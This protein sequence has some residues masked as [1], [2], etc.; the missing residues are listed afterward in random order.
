MMVVRGRIDCATV[1]NKSLQVHV[2]LLRLSSRHGAT[3]RVIASSFMLGIVDLDSIFRP[4]Q[5]LQNR[6]PI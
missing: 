1:P 5:R 4:M 3:R 6:R 2:H